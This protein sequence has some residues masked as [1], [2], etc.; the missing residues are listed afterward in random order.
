VALPWWRFGHD[1]RR[2]ERRGG[3]R[4]AAARGGSDRR[5]GDRRAATQA[6][7]LSV[8]AVSMPT[9]ADADVFTKRGAGG[10]LEATN[11]PDREGFQLAYRSKG[12]VTHAPDFRLSPANNRRYDLFIQEASSLHGVDQGLV[13]AVIQVE[14][15]FDARAVS[16]A[17]ARGLMQIMPAT[18]ER[19]GVADPF[20]PRQNILG[21]VKYL[22]KLL[23]MFDGDVSL[24]VAGYNAGEHAVQ[25][26]NGVPPYKE[27]QGYVRKILSLLGGAQERPPSASASRVAAA[28]AEPVQKKPGVIYKWRDSQGRMFLSDTPPPGA[29]P[30]VVVTRSGD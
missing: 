17:G 16:R 3:E 4:R 29:T 9:F 15:E 24:A 27:T 23:N 21:G 11:L 19:F 10:V 14:S 26:H 30:Y 1:R 8:M 22:R 25:R 2:N 5:N 28:T 6:V 13:R 7:L 18:A 12:P 20:D